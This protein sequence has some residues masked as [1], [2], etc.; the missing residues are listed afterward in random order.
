MSTP[1]TTRA[2]TFA[3]RGY[4]NIKVLGYRDDG[5]QVVMLTPSK[6]CSNVKHSKMM[7]NNITRRIE[8]FETTRDRLRKKLMEKN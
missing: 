4:T 1:K 5:E 6:N 2:E 7:Q 3:A 8:S